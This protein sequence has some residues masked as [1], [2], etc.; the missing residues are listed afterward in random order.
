[1]A[2]S[3]PFSPL[4]KS[5]QE[6]ARSPPAQITDEVGDPFLS[7]LPLPKM[8]PSLLA[9]DPATIQATLNAFAH[10]DQLKLLFFQ[11]SQKTNYSRNPLAGGCPL[12]LY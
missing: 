7:E 11:V 2:D 1:M 6:Q 3:A 8:L 4:L 10:A 5:V 9:A 12:V